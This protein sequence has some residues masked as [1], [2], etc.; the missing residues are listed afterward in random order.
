LYFY[1]GGIVKKMKNKETYSDFSNVEKQR[2]YLLPEEL[3][4]GPYGAPRGESSPVE[5][6]STPWK[7]GQRYTSAFTYENKSLHQ[8]LPRQ[9]DGAHP[10]H[11]DPDKNEQAPYSATP[12]E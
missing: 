3:P 11:D 6:K 7:A 5:N 12:N 1:N 2:N 4:E 9:M 8:G 10:P